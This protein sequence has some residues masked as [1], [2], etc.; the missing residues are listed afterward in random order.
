MVTITVYLCYIIYTMSNAN[1]NVA[2]VQGTEAQKVEIPSLATVE[3]WVAR[4]VSTSIR[5]LQAIETDPDLRRMVAQWCLGK[6]EN[7]KNKPI[8]DPGQTNIFK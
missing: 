1:G 3:K 7:Y 6:L 2:E 8:V 4:D 5:F